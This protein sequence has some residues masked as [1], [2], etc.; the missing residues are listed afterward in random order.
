MPPMGV[1]GFV[2]HPSHLSTP[3]PPIPQRRVRVLPIALPRYYVSTSIFNPII[4]LRSV[5]SV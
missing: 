5:L 2:P 4:Y 1:P 3:M